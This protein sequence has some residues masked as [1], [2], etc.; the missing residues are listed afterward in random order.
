VGFA[1]KP[2][3]HLHGAQWVAMTRD[4]FAMNSSRSGMTSSRHIA[5]PEVLGAG[6]VTAAAQLCRL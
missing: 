5:S 2:D 3:I 6:I 1:L 4:D